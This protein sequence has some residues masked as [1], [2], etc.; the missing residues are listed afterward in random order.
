MKSTDLPFLGGEA[1][2]LNQLAKETVPTFILVPGILGS[3]L[4][5]NETIIWGEKSAKRLAYDFSDSQ[6]YKTRNPVDADF[7]Y[8]FIAPLWFDNADIYETGYDAIKYVLQNSDVPLLPFGYDWRQPIEGSARDLD[9]KIKNAWRDELADRELVLIA[10]S[11]GGLVVTWWYHK[12]Y[13]PNK[14][15]YP[16]NVLRQTI[17]LGTP[18]SGSPALLATLIEGYHR[19]TEPGWI[20]AGIDDHIFKNLN[21]DVITFPS[22]FELLPGATDRVKIQKPSGLSGPLPKWNKVD[23]FNY[24]KWADFDWLEISRRLNG[25]PDRPR[26]D[27]NQIKNDPVKKEALKQYLEFYEKKIGPLL[28]HGRDF[29]RALAKLPLIDSALYFY[30]ESQKTPTSIKVIPSGRLTE[31]TYKTEIKKV[32]FSGD[33]SVPTEVAQNSG[34]EVTSFEI[35]S[36]NTIQTVKPH[37]ELL[38]DWRFRQFIRN[39]LEKY[40]RHLVNKIVEQNDPTIQE[41]FRK[42]GYL[43]PGK[44]TPILDFNEPLL[45]DRYPSLSPQ[46]AAGELGAYYDQAKNPAESSKA[47]ILMEGYM[48][49]QGYAGDRKYSYLLKGAD[50]LFKDFRYAE[51]VEKLYKIDRLDEQGIDSKTVAF[52]EHMFAYALY[53]LGGST[54]QN[55]ALV[56]FLK[57]HRLEPDNPKYRSDAE[58]AERGF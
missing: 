41:A 10:H 49:A 21:K 12:F 14:S 52:K 58:W 54:N 9:E 46:A 24:K 20:A 35:W 7:M 38:A 43:L 11:M 27:P 3:R 23:H 34:K 33:G 8:S 28:A 6:G 25:I 48:D 17:F 50:M 44:A 19:E 31:R 15:S 32:E 56:R 22:V 55:E 29:Q 30:T 42:W 16:F 37:G 36:Y 5:K 40:K 4:T 39:F 13:L 26:G 57:A 45:K 1:E 18:H 2:S 47:Y 53:R 51:A